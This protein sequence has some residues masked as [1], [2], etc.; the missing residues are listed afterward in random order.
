M[1]SALADLSGRIGW[2]N[3]RHSGSAA[4]REDEKLHLGSP[5]VVEEAHGRQESESH[6]RG[7]QLRR[8]K[9]WRG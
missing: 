5:P 9:P 3:E 1:V 2:N 4:S 7:G 6:G 8:P